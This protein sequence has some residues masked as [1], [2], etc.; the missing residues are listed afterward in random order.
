MDFSLVL[1][2]VGRQGTT[3]ICRYNCTHE[4]SLLLASEIYSFS[5]LLS[6]EQAGLLLCEHACLQKIRRKQEGDLLCSAGRYASTNPDGRSL[7]TVA[8]RNTFSILQ[9]QDLVGQL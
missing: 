6:V 4:Y 7:C 5:L 2:Y 8:H 1:G 3:R 9:I